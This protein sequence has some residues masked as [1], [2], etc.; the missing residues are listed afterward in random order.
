ME[1][2]LTLETNLELTFGL[3]FE[4]LGHLVHD[5]V[6]EIQSSHLQILN[7]VLAIIKMPVR[8]WG[9]GRHFLNANSSPVC[10]S[11]ASTLPFLIEASVIRA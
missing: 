3:A 5:N 2:I 8:S 9:H 11:S 6:P 4:E 7:I 1:T 10:P